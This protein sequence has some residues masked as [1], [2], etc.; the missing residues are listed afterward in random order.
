MLKDSSTT[1]NIADFAVV[2]LDEKNRIIYHKL[3]DCL[4]K[5]KNFMNCDGFL[6]HYSDELGSWYN[7]TNAVPNVAIRSYIPPEYQTLLDASRIKKIV[8]DLIDSAEIVGTFKKNEGLINVKNGV[9]NL[10]TLQL[11]EHSREFGFNYVNNFNYQSD[12]KITDATS[13]CSYILSSIGCESM[14]S[15]EALQVLEVI[16]YVV[17][18]L[19]S[20][21]KAIIALGESNTGKS[22]F[23]KILEMVFQADEISSVGLHELNSPFRFSALAYSRINLLHEVKPV[24]IKCVDEFKKIVSCED[25]IAEDKGQRPRRVRPRTVWVSAANSMPDFAGME[26]NNSIVNR[27]LVIRFLGAVEPDKINRNLLDELAQE[28]DIIFSVGVK[29]L[30]ALMNKGY[31]FT[32]PASTICFMEAYARS[33]NSVSLFITECC[34]INGGEKVFSKTLY[35]AYVDFVKKNMLYKNSDYT[36]GM[37]V[38]S[39][40]G[41]ENKKIRIGKVNLQGYEGIGLKIQSD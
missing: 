19:R 22:V 11:I 37:Q 10:K 6:Y 36:F 5:T 30:P 15:E 28:I 38:R 31:L 39:L 26:L 1:V 7:I 2:C 32:I 16:G 17:S 34:E 12:A 27:L 9:I 13:F 18:E 35:N 8:A 4:I 23:L 24:R 40:K 21:E 3:L 20:A 14:D 25:I 33:L 29:A 41:V